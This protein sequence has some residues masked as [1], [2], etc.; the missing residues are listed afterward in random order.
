MKKNYWQWKAK[1]KKS[2]FSLNP[3]R[4]KIRPNVLTFQDD[5]VEEWNSIYKWCLDHYTEVDPTPSGGLAK[6]WNTTERYMVITKAMS[7]EL[8]I[9]CVEGCYRFVLK[10]KPSEDNVVKGRKSALE[11]YRQ[12]DAFK[13]DLS[14]Y[15]KHGRKAKDEIDHPHI[16]FLMPERFLG[17]VFS[18]VCHLDLNSAYASGIVK[19]YPELREMYESMYAK[20]KDDDDYFKHVLT[21]SVGCF[22]SEYC[23]DYRNRIK[24]DPF[25]FSDLS[26]AAIN[27]TRK[28]IEE[29]MKRLS[30]SGRV[31]I[32]TN[33]D[34]IWY[35]GTPY[36]AKDE[37]DG[38][39]KWKNDHVN[40]DLLVKSRGAYQ[41]ME[42]GVCHTVVRGISNLDLA[43]PRE[44]WKF[45]EIMSNDVRIKTFSFE[46]GKGV[47]EKWLNA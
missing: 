31:P 32:L 28:R 21:N 14:T 26:K 33:T 4:K 29:L 13:I 18:G 10:N 7:F 16:E 15:A 2:K 17:H 44:E 45:G 41:Y 27:N 38:L 23:P 42:D 24:A 43:K 34:G 12:S 40:C 5:D 46:K 1:Y 20:R 35:L 11:V 30:K 3:N 9:V 36:H 22:Q 47:M 37:G 39:G 6:R 8:V 25:M 19:E